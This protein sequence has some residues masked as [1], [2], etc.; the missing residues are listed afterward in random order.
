MRAALMLLIGSL[1]YSAQSY[2]LTTSAPAGVPASLPSAVLASVS[3]FAAQAHWATQAVQLAK[4]SS[5]SRSSS[6]RRSDRPSVVH[7]PSRSS[8]K[9]TRSS[10]CTP[11]PSEATRFAGG[12]GAG[13][14]LSA[15]AN[16]RNDCGDRYGLDEQGNTAGGF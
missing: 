16:D 4:R 9:N 3:P 15:N 13:N 2:C 10:D 14:K 1:A 8:S 11:Q 12:E 6:S 5:S 7:T